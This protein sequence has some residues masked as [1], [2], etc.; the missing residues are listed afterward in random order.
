MVPPMPDD[1]HSNPSLSAQNISVWR[2]GRLIFKGLNIDLRAGQ[3]LVV[4]GP[5]G[6]GKSTLL[7]ILAGLLRPETGTVTTSPEDSAFARYSG[8]K[9][10]LKGAL[11]VR[12][13]LDFWASL[14]SLPE[15]EIEKT[16]DTL[17]LHKVSDMPTDILSAGWKRRVGL[18]RM[19]LGQAPLW[20]LDE[21]YTSLDSENIARLDTVL[22]AHTG[23]G[24]LIV[25]ATH[26]TTGFAPTHR[27]DM[28]DYQ[29]KT[30]HIREESW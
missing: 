6:S 21:P 18:A 17:D 11:T 25:L 16:L 8:H 26:Q 2:G 12:E 13:N 14:Y 1:P 9:N 27:I 15:S 29:P 5:N 23:S 20:I 4:T 28:T 19:A 30:V 3:S 22:T 10:G 7:R 24:G